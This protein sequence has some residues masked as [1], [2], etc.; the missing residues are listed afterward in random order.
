MQY[1]GYH[2]PKVSGG[3][4]STECNHYLLRLAL[5]SL[6]APKIYYAYLQLGN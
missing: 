6:Q 2:F 5:E 1:N 4:P 3:M